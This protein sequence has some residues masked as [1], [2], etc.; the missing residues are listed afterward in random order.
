MKSF[1]FSTSLASFA[2][3]ELCWK[4]D[5]LLS[6]NPTIFHIQLRRLIEYFFFVGEGLVSNMDRWKRNSRPAEF[7]DCRSIKPLKSLITLAVNYIFSSDAAIAYGVGCVHR[8]DGADG[9]LTVR[10]PETLAQQ[11]QSPVPFNPRIILGD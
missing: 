6:I 10:M 1:I 7:I 5:L 8:C 4:A 2:C 11:F 9:T 3:V